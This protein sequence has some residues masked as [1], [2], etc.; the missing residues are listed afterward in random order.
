[1]TTI[2]ALNKLRTEEIEKNE[3]KVVKSR[4]DEKNS[5]NESLSID[6]INSLL[7]EYADVMEEFSTNKSIQLQEMEMERADAIDRC[8]SKGKV[9]I[10]HFEKIEDREDDSTI[11]HW[12]SEMFT[13]LADVRD[14]VLKHN[15]KLILNGNLRDWFFTAGSEPEYIM[16]NPTDKKLEDYDEFVTRLFSKGIRSI[17]QKDI[18]DIINEM[19]L[20]ESILNES[21]TNKEKLKLYHLS[22]KQLNEPLIPRIP[23]SDYEDQETP[24]VCFSKSIQGSLIGIN[25]DKDIT[26]KTFYVYSL[27]T[28]DYYEPTENEVADVDITDEVWIL[29]ECEPKFEYKIKVTGIKDSREEII[30]GE[31][32]DVPVWDYEKIEDESLNEVYPNKRESKED[33]ISRF[34]KVTKDE[35]PDRKQRYAVALSYWDRRNGSVE[36]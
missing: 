27:T 12:T 23:K 31:I 4:V 25:E 30:K 28:D 24:R 26:G 9:F 6:Y 8:I 3:K 16:R 10:E 5:I 1:M 11:N 19:V 36:D 7:D 21:N 20:N 32:F 17:T 34:M 2:E 35:Y 18:L 15:N 13:Q 14:I 22:D 29:H 33:F